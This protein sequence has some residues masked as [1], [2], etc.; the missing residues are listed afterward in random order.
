MPRYAMLVATNAAAGRDDEFN[1]WYDNRHLSD[2]LS[3]DGFISAQRFRLADTDPEQSAPQR[4][5]AIYEVEAPSPEAAGKVLA[6]G[7]G[8]GKLP[9][10]EALDL[11]SLSI[12]YY[13]PLTDRRTG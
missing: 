4:Y 2:V 12:L 8:S 11:S 6:D 9:V 7:F 1:E 13:E 10:S 3:L 5:L